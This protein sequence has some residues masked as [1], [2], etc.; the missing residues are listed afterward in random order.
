MLYAVAVRTTLIFVLVLAVP[1][2]ARASRLVP[3]FAQEAWAETMDRNT[4]PRRRSCL[5]SPA[6]RCP[7]ASPWCGP[8]DGDDESRPTRREPRPDRP[9][10]WTA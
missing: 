9:A 8:R 1:R 4:Q 7:L 2:T 5:A 3:C 10:F 6:R